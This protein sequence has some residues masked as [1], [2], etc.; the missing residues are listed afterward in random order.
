MLTITNV[1]T[2]RNFK[3]IPGTFN[4]VGTY[5]SGN[6]AQVWTNKLHN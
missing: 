2:V 3:V 6:Y 4:S 1:G 5:F